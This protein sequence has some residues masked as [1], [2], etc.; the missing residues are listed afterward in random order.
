MEVKLY[1]IYRTFLDNLDTNL[2]QDVLHSVNIADL[3]SIQ[4]NYEEEND[5]KNHHHSNSDIVVALDLS[6]EDITVKPSS[7]DITLV[8]D[9]TNDRSIFER[10]GND[11]CSILL[12]FFYA[13]FSRAI[14]NNRRNYSR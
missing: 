13:S 9:E 12:L 10:E 1:S 4:E 5:E 6:P 11:R 14:E 8:S 7:S 3:H 2:D